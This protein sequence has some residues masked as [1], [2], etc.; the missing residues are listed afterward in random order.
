VTDNWATAFPEWLRAAG[1]ARSYTP[2]DVVARG[3]VVAN[4][5]SEAGTFSYL[6]AVVGVGA[7]I[8]L[9]DG[10]LWLVIGFALFAGGIW[11]ARQR[12]SEVE[13]K[14]QLETAK[15][16]AAHLSA[17]RELE[18]ALVRADQGD[19][20]AIQLL[21]KRWWNY[22]DKSLSNITFDVVRQPDGGFAVAGRGINRVEVPDMTP[23]IGRG[24]RTF[25]DKR[26]AAEID[27]ELAEQNAGAVVAALCAMF[28]GATQARVAVRITIQGGDG[29][30]IPWVTIATIIDGDRLKA[31]LARGARP[32]E[33]LKA[34]GGDVGRCRNQRYTAAAE[35]AWGALIDASASSSPLTD[36]SVSLETLASASATF[37]DRAK[38]TARLA[39]SLAASAA[40]VNFDGP[41]RASVVSQPVPQ[42]PPRAQPAL[43][44][45]VSVTG[46]GGDFAAEAEKRMRVVGNPNAPYVPFQSYWSTYA[47]MNPAQTEFY[48]RW[49]TAARSGQFIATDLSYIF[50]HV[51]ELLHLIGAT[52]ATDATGQLTRMWL[53]YRTTFPKLDTYLVPWITDLY[54]TEV[55]VEAALEF[56]K[57]HVDIHT[58]QCDELLLT[59][60]PLWAAGDYGSMTPGG[61]AMLL[62]ERRLGDNKFVREHNTDF[63]G[64]PWVEGAYKAAIRAADEAYRQSSGR[65]PRERTIKKSG[66]RM[67]SRPAFASAVYSWKRRQVNLAKVPKLTDASPSVELY[68]GVTRHSENL[69]RAER[70]FR[71]RLRGVEL[72]PEIAAAVDACIVAYIRAT[73]PRARVT[74]DV[75]RAQQLAQESAHTR[76]RLLQ[77]LDSSE[78]E[79][80]ILAPDAPRADGLLTDV[81]AVASVMHQLTAPAEALVIALAG[82]GWELPENS[83]ELIA[84]TGGVLVGPLVDE[85]NGCALEAL[86]TALIVREADRLVV[87]EDYR[88]EVYYI[89][90][91]NLDGFSPVVAPAHATPSAS[92]PLEAVHS[93]GP[94][95]L[96]TLLA[97]VDGANGGPAALAALAAAHA[98]TPLMLVDSL[99]ERA[100]DSSYG[101]IIVD[102]DANPPAILEDA[103]EFVASI[104]QHLRRTGGEVA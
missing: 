75:T 40:E 67:V 93:F 8:I 85:V 90:R 96:Q 9:P 28:G 16:R 21:L 39:N 11:R 30:R 29:R 72:S 55:S 57:S 91:G 92:H 69:L 34:L 36:S 51:Y 94:V 100:V 22:V 15:L 104:L 62:T 19:I 97:I 99:N 37:R 101:D 10:W 82:E 25:Y 42:P 98:S 65:S 89:V 60:D 54:A 27:T 52:H 102:A 80:S 88:D 64:Q 1:A 41:A 23:R 43:S 47:H 84:A 45:S 7:A 73:K 17:S 87:Q 61:L 76:D 2:F 33:A 49:R 103:E 26:K 14:L 74:I 3:R 95:E 18:A 4:Q 13:A 78:K 58:P 66:Q 38:R 63:E 70:G 71:G 44:I 31:V 20:D 81:D 32:S 53:G 5:L 35:P 77:G 79:V 83:D 12:R 68:R 86:G 56:V 59:V 6:P 46:L 48:F 50:I 24:G